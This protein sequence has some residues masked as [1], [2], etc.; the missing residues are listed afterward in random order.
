MDARAPALSNWKAANREPPYAVDD[1]EIVEW[2]NDASFRRERAAW[3]RD[4]QR[5]GDVKFAN[6]QVICSVV[7]GYMGAKDGSAWPSLDRLAADLGWSKKT[8]QRA[9]DDAVRWGWLSKSR[10]RL[11]NEYLMSFSGEVRAAVMQWHADRIAA[12]EAASR[13]KKALAAMVRFDHSERSEL[14]TANGQTCPPA[15]VKPDHQSCPA[16]SIIDP[17][18][19]SET[20]R[21]G[22]GE[23]DIGE[24]VEQKKT[25]R[26][27]V[28][29]VLG[30]GDLQAGE[31]AAATLGPARLAYLVRLVDD[32]GMVGAHRAIMQ[33]RNSLAPQH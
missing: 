4:I 14:T 22:E 8:V 10:K 20:E 24:G 32:E 16:S 9:L 11:S 1:V 27:E 30:H 6:M 18:D 2:G 13:Q 28:I 12:F 26:D 15:M 17:E 7:A 25:S 3:L 23:Q 33:A 19:R 31:H 29:S 21:L 5:M